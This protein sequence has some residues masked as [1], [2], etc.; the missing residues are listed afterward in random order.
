MRPLAAAVGLEDAGG[1]GYDFHTALVDHVEG[2][3]DDDH[4]A[5]IR[6]PGVSFDQAGHISGGHRHQGDGEGKAESHD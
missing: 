2:N 6:N 5:D 3:D 1:G 4:Q